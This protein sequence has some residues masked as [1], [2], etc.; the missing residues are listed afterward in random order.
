MLVFVYVADR[1]VNARAADAGIWK[2]GVGE[3]FYRW[4]SG[5]TAWG[6]RLLLG[7]GA[8]RLSGGKISGGDRSDDSATYGQ[9]GTGGLKT[10]GT[11]R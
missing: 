8:T 9:S 7:Q 6:R 5:R 1:F 2:S 3:L 4:D 10:V 11:A